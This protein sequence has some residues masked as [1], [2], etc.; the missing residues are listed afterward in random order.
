MSKQVTAFRDLEDA[1]KSLPRN[2]GPIRVLVLNRQGLPVLQYS[3]SGT[4]Q[5]I[6]DRDCALGTELAREVFEIIRPF[7][8]KLP[9]SVAFHYPEE[10][11][12]VSRSGPFVI[13]V[14]W[15]A[16]AFKSIV[17]NELYVKRLERTLYEELY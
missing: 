3:N 16:V 5:K 13:L 10:V 4:V 12:T 14:T 9:E 7:H 2:K 8:G 6:S 17:A 15:P 1:R 11:I